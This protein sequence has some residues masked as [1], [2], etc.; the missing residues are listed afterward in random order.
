MVP[1]SELTWGALGRRPAA[2]HD[3]ARLLPILRLWRS[4]L[5]LEDDGLRQGRRRRRGEDRQGAQRV[6]PDLRAFKA[7]GGKLI[8]YHGWNDQLI[9]PLNTVNYYNSVAKTMGAKE[10][11]DFARLFMAPGMQ[12]CAGGAGTKH[13]RR[14][15]ARSSSGW[16]RARKPARDRRVARDQWRRRSHASAVSVSAGGHLH[17]LGQHRRGGELRLQVSAVSR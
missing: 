16:R 3:R 8:M 12:H 11:D 9:S 6:D 17:G 13:L 2:V 7:R 4:E 1:G 14:A 15:R 5:G 10:T